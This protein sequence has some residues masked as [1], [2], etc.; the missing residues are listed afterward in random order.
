MTNENFL[1]FYPTL[2]YMAVDKGDLENNPNEQTFNSQ[3]AEIVFEDIKPEY[4]LR[5][6][7]DGRIL[8]RLHNLE[9]PENSETL[10]RNQTESIIEHYINL[11][12]ILNLFLDSALIEIER[13]HYFR[14]NEITI[15]HSFICYSRGEDIAT[16]SWSRHY[17]ERRFWST[18]NQCVPIGISAEIY[19]SR[20]VSRSTLERVSSNFERVFSDSNL[21]KDIALL[22]RSLSA[23]QSLSN[24]TSFTIAWF[25]I[26]GK[27][28]Q[29]VRDNQLLATPCNINDE[30]RIYEII[31]FLNNQR[32]ISNEVS[33]QAHQCRIIR[34][35]ISHRNSNFSL[36]TTN[37]LNCLQL[38]HTLIQ[39]YFNFQ[40]RIGLSRHALPF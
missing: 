7:R 9:I 32:L 5:F 18:H 26:E 28:R 12:N 20:V 23:Y 17:Q 8:L 11:L 34:N 19:I 16:Q 27:C 38:A 4:T 40:F 24:E 1:A 22:S 2:P 39:N 15:N 25:I 31:N 14:V 37:T 3:M 6:W 33:G 35:D 36:Q 10:E 13:V 21:T 29:I 30:S